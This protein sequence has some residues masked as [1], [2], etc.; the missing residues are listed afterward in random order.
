M[1]GSSL[2]ALLEKGPEGVVADSPKK[3][4]HLTS[5]EGIG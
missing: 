5:T 3:A 1:L 2:T 4:F